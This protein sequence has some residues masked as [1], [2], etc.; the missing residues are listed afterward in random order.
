MRDIE[1]RIN[2][3]YIKPCRELWTARVTWYETITTEKQIKFWFNCEK[4]CF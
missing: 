2:E 1:G 3:S 4:T